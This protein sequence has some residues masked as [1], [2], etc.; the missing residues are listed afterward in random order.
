MD[1]ITRALLDEFVQQNDI[2]DLPEDEAFADFAGSLMISSH[3]SESFSGEEIVVGAGGDCGIDAI[4]IIV[5]GNLVTEPE[6]VIDL[7]D[8]NGYLDVAFIFVQ[9]KRTSSFESSKISHF[10]FGVSDFFLEKP[11]L[12]Q[13]ERLRHYHQMMQ[14]VFK[15]SKLFTKGNPQCALYY[16]TTGRWTEDVNLSVRDAIL[17]KRIFK[18]PVYFVRLFMT[19]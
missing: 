15:K 5:N 14:E 2:A 10:G 4:G 9:A 17:S 16:V 1:M 6:E 18:R 11:N 19:V 13:N 8:T 7:A 3:Y 12:P